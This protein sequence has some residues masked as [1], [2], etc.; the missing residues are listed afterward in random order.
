VFVIPEARA[1]V[2]VCFNPLRVSKDTPPST[3]GLIPGMGKPYLANSGNSQ[4]LP[5]VL[6]LVSRS[7][8]TVN[9]V[10][11]TSIQGIELH[12]KPPGR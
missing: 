3:K 10:I 4:A 7:I 8:L 11:Q 2:I 6:P 1:L 5:V 12:P 9:V